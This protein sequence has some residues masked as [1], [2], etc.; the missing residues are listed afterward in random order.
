M[1]KSEF[2]LLRIVLNIIFGM[3]S[4]IFG[5]ISIIFIIIGGPASG[6]LGTLWGEAWFPGYAGLISRLLGSAI[7]LLCISVF[8]LCTPKGS[9]RFFWIALCGL[10]PLLAYLLF[11]FARLGSNP[12]K[13]SIAIDI[14]F[15]CLALVW[16]YKTRRPA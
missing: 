15:L 11:V 4:F 5:L 9:A 2:S 6:V 8:V 1:Q 13:L 7:G 16:L 10:L 12:M 3:L 14:V